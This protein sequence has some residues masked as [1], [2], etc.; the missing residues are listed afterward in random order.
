MATREADSRLLD[1]LIWGTLWL[2][3]LVLWGQIARY[4]TRGA[5]ER[6]RKE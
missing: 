2:Q 1:R 3:L 4:Q 5:L 6:E